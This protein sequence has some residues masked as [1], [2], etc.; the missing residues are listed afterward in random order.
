ATHPRIDTLV[1]NAGIHSLSGRTSA[2]G[3]DL[4]TATNHLGP[5]LLTNLLLEPIVAAERARIVITASEAHRSWPR[6][7]LER[8][9]EARRYNAIRSEIRYGQSKLMNIL[10][11]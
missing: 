1:N 5:F 6:I 8:F 7:D 9:A 10:F 4:M 3:F 2:D 11:T